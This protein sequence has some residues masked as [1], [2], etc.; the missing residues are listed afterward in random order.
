MLDESTHTTSLLEIRRFLEAERAAPAPWAEPRESLESLYAL[1]VA[2]RDDP[3][4][5]ARLEE[6]VRRLEDH[7][8]NLPRLARSEAFGYA[9]VEK[10]LA[11]LRAD[12]R[13]GADLAPVS[14]KRALASS[15]QATSLAGFLLLGTASASCG[16][17][18][19]AP[20]S[21]AADSG[22]S[23][24]DGEIYC[25]LVDIV[26]DSQLDPM[27]QDALLECLPDLDAAY[28]EQLLESFQ[29]MDD[30]ALND[31]LWQMLDYGGACYEEDTDAH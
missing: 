31:A 10:L 19:T 13:K 26:R 7:R 11:D 1:L 29:T 27:N 21:E 8:V 9:T 5:W 24:E 23:G 6:L 3:R 28:R 4:F 12:L 22:I 14:W 17:D 20:C 18:S 16:D 2:R 25:E 15:L 30:D